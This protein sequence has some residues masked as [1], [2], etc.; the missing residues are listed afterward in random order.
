MS[1]QFFFDG[2]L[3]RAVGGI[4]TS[5]RRYLYFRH[6]K[7]PR[8]VNLVTTFTA[9]TIAP[10]VWAVTWEGQT[11]GRMQ[12]ELAGNVLHRD[13]GYFTADP[14]DSLLHR[15]DDDTVVFETAYGGVSYREEIRYLGDDHRLR[16]TVGRNED[17]EWVIAGQYV[18]WRN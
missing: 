2:W 5:E 4:W 15:I 6:P 7:P 13:I 16:Q 11:N 18:E 10:Q 9:E 14:T 12:L 8:N 3:E 17:R 1:N